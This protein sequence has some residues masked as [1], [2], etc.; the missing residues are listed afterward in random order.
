MVFTLQIISRCMPH[1]SGRLEKVFSNHTGVNIF[2]RMLTG[3]GI[4][5]VAE[6]I[7]HL[8]WVHFLSPVVDDILFIFFDVNNPFFDLES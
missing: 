2:V 6:L 4:S 7:M 1:F 8:D 3:E 5:E